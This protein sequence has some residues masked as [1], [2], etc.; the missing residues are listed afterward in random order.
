MSIQYIFHISLIDTSSHHNFLS[1]HKL[2]V[3]FRK[4]NFAFDFQ[5]LLFQFFK[6]LVFSHFF[7]VSVVVVFV[8][9]QFF[10]I[11]IQFLSKCPSICHFFRILSKHSLSDWYF[12]FIRPS[13]YFLKNKISRSKSYIYW[14]FFEFIEFSRFRETSIVSSTFFYLLTSSSR[15]RGEA[16]RQSVSAKN[17]SRLTH[18]IKKKSRVL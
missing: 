2:F 3:C 6:F 11:E 4:C 9:S 17:G 7:K 1:Y 18:E 15:L 16:A 13:S 12:N 8:I 5:L 10:S 14:N